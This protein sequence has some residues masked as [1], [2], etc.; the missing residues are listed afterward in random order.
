MLYAP[1]I[2]TRPPIHLAAELPRLILSR[3]YPQFPKF[4]YAFS[5]NFNLCLLD[6]RYKVIYNV[7]QSVAKWGN[8]PTGRFSRQDVWGI[9]NSPPPSRSGEVLRVT[10]C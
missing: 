7:G 9:A 8:I 10:C 6:N 5:Q 2:R 1:A 4:N 3:S